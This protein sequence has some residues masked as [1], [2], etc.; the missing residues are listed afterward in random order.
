VPARAQRQ[1]VEVDV[2]H[3]RTVVRDASR[4]IRAFTY[5]PA[6]EYTRLAGR[7]R[8]K[9]GRD[10]NSEFSAVALLLTGSATR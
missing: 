10:V 3:G 2:S 7:L 6:A 1:P 4:R 9:E 5:G 8:R